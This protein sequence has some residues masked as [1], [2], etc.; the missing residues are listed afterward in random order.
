MVDPGPAVEAH[1]RT[2]L[3]GLGSAHEVTILLTHHHA[4]HAGATSELA[5]RS[6]ARVLAPPSYS[7]PP[8]EGFEVDYL[9]EGQRITTDQG[10]LEVLRI[11]GHTSDH[12]GFHWRP[13]DALFVGDLVLGRGHTTWVGE[14]L[15]C[16]QDYLSS[17]ERL[18][19]I[20]PEVLYPGHGP[21]V[22]SP[23]STL[24]M[25]RS[26]RLERLKEVRSARS[27]YPQAPPADLATLIYGRAIP[28]ALLGAA[29][30]S[31][32]ASLFHLEQ[33][34]ETLEEPPTGGRG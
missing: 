11:P 18:L 10:D 25:F 13:P 31:V 27:R 32:E 34:A 1:I 21:A 6:G 19:R 30:R 20:S 26:H 3:H 22:R 16:V 9:E 29:V 7:P 24:E 8:G 12:V 4:D 14:Y 5:V 23:R 33:E 15:G 2:L 17:L 28:E